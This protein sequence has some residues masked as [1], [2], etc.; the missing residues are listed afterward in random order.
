MISS[1]MVDWKPGGTDHFHS[2]HEDSA[3]WKHSPSSYRHGNTGDRE[4]GFLF[5]PQISVICG[6]LAFCE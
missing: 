2:V 6:L 3:V 4:L 5:L 1:V